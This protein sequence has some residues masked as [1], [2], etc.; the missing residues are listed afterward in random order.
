MAH[1]T[2]SKP[3]NDRSEQAPSLTELTTAI[4]HRSVCTL[5]TSSSRNRPHAATVIYAAVGT[6]LYVNTDR[7]SR[8]ARNVAENPHVGVVIHVRRLPVGPPS[9]VQLQGTAEV[10][11]MDDPEIVALVEAGRLKKVTGHGEL[12]RPDG[13]FIRIRP[14]RKV[15][16]YG[17]GMSLWQL[18]RDPLNAA[19]SIELPTDEGERGDA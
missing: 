10:V 14:G 2:Q 5:A 8:K 1:N 9:S 12:D 13:C 17:L 3:D 19:G 15:T 4:G 7:S 11:D 18:L 16:T 6:T